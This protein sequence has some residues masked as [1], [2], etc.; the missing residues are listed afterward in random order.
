M[1]LGAPVQ[2]AYDPAEPSGGRAVDRVPKIG[3]AV[4]LFV[5]GAI[6]ILAALE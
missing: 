3:C 6:L 5:L 4:I 2:V 1:T